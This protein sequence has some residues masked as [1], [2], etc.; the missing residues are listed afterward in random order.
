MP[1][2]LPPD[3]AEQWLDR[4]LTDAGKVM[5]LLQPNPDDAIAFYRVGI[6]VSNARNQGVELI[7]AVKG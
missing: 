2:V 7:E 5:A 6:R 1:F 3:R 4:K